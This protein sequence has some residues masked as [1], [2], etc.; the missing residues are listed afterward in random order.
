VALDHRHDR[1]VVALAQLVGVHLPEALPVPELRGGRVHA[2][3]EH[4]VGERTLL[5]GAIA[6]GQPR[7]HVAPHLPLDVRERRR[8]APAQVGVDHLTGEIVGEQPVGAGLHERQPAQPREQGLALLLAEGGAQQAGGGEARSRR[9]LERPPVA[10]ARHAGEEALDQRRH[11]VRHVG[12]LERRLGLLADH[13][14]QQRERQRMA[15]RE[16]EHPLVEGLRDAPALEQSPRVLA[17]EVA[18]GHHPQE[19]LPARVAPP[20]LAR[21]RAAGDHSQRA[22]RQRRDERLPQPAL[23]AERRL[24][25]VQQQHRAIPARERVARGH[26]GRQPAQASDLGR[27]GRGRGLD[28]AQVELQR[29][30]PEVRRLVGERAQQGGLADPAGPDDPQHAERWV[31]RGQR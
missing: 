5:L 25:G 3:Q 8:I 6:G 13:V 20:R 26:V 22:A 4:Q 12:Q 29:L 28:P 21:T 15:V 24:D 1:R 16:L 10:R 30:A 17:T 19:L 27:E 31:G 18:Q 23:Q 7:D 14:E 11:H 2:M 9:Q